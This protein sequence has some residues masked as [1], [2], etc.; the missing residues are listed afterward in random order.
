MFALYQKEAAVVTVVEEIITGRP[1]LHAGRP[2]STIPVNHGSIEGVTRNYT[3]HLRCSGTD[4]RCIL[5]LVKI[6]YN[7]IAAINPIRSVSGSICGGGV[8]H[9]VKRM[10]SKINIEL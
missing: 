8:A 6:R 3:A 9:H 4:R 1:L 2:R 10:L 5:P 7:F